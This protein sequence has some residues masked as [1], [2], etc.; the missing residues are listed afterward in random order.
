MQNETAP[1]LT[2][3][4][5]LDHLAAGKPALD[6]AE[7]PGIFTL[8]NLSLAVRDR[9]QHRH[10]QEAAVR[11][12]LYSQ[13]VHGRR[14]PRRH[15]RRG[16]DGTGRDAA[17]HPGLGGNIE[18]PDREAIEDARRVV[19]ADGGPPNENSIT[20]SGDTWSICYGA[21]KG[22]YS[23]GSNKCI[24]WL[25]KLLHS[26]LRL[27]TAAELRGDPEG[28]LAADCAIGA[29]PQGGT[30]RI[31]ACRRRLQEIEDIMEEAGGSESLENEKVSLL[32]DLENA[33][34]V[35]QMSRPARNAHHN[36]ATQLRSFCKRLNADMPTLSA[37]LIAC[38]QL[39]FPHFV[40]TPPVGNKS[41]KT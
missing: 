13:Q 3:Q 39:D 22:L 10:F 38:L 2:V 32:R 6:F 15:L 36:I 9:P 27:L 18:R 30:L 29:R 33:D 20:L 12:L 19:L 4:R 26:P 35:R 7:T 5:L 24:G 31:V 21:E 1:V 16:R 17:R 41:W 8:A 11:R 14:G 28:K 37:H 25:V 34:D 40:Y 23:V